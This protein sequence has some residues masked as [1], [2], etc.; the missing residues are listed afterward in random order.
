MTDAAR[1]AYVEYKR[2]YEPE[3]EIPKGFHVHHIT[4]VC[5]GGTDT[6]SNLIALHPD[7]HVSIHTH[8]GDK[9]SRSGFHVMSAAIY[10]DHPRVGTKHSVESRAKMSAAAKKRKVNPMQGRKHSEAAKAKM[11]EQAL[12]R[13]TNGMLGRKHSEET[14]AKI[15]AARV[16]K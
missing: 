6:G 11:R 12:K 3:Y 10:K 14:K 15:R 5:E 7:D 2:V 16:S 9:V 8:R 4:P 13:K 1:K